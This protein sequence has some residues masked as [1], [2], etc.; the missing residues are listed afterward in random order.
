[1]NRGQFFL[2]LLLSS[3]VVAS[4]VSHVSEVT[5]AKAQTP[6]DYVRLNYLVLNETTDF[7]P[8]D[9]VVLYLS[10]E[11]VGEE[12]LYDLSL[13]QTFD[14]D[15][16]III[17][18]APA[19]DTLATDATELSYNWDRLNSEEKVTF[20]T[21][22]KVIS[23]EPEDRVFLDAPTIAFKVTEA[24]LPVSTEANSLEVGVYVAEETTEAK[25]RVLGDIDSGIIAFAFLFVLPIA[26]MFLLSFVFGRRKNK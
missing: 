21:T 5:P 18:T 17:S 16:F 4:Q 1:M 10:I 25:E 20:N 2:L 7:Q 12:P 23:D 14:E 26:L 15:Y 9:T 22:L 11:N 6:E 8:N 24:R 19:I 3:V 13:N